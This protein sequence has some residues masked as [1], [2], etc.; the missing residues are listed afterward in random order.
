MA[1][2]SIGDGAKIEGTSTPLEVYNELYYLTLESISLAERRLEID[3]EIFKRTE[4]GTG[5]TV[6]DSGTTVSF[7][8]TGAYYVLRD[9]VRK[10]LD[11]RLEK[12][13][14]PGVP[15]V[16]PE[17]SDL[18]VVGIMA[19]QHYN[20]AYDLAASQLY[21]SSKD[22][23]YGDKD[24]NLMDF[25]PS[26]SDEVF[27]MNMPKEYNKEASKGQ[28]FNQE[29]M[30]VT[31]YSLSDME[32]DANNN[33]IIFTNEDMEIAFPNHRRPLYLEGQI[34]DVFIRQALVDIG[35]SVNSLPLAVLTEVGIPTSKVVRSKISINWFRNSSEE[36]IGYIE[37]DLK[38]SPINPKY[39][40]V[41]HQTSEIPKETKDKH[42]LVAKDESLQ[43]I[44]HTPK[45]LDKV[46]TIETLMP[47]NKCKGVEKLG[48]EAVLH[49]VLHPRISSSNK[50]LHPNAQ[51]REGIH[52]LAINAPFPEEALEGDDWK[53]TVRRELSKPSGEL[54]VKC[55]KKYI[56]VNRTLYK[57]LSEGMLTRSLRQKEAQEQLHKTHETTCE[58][59]EV[60]S[61]YR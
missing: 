41:A 60:V 40:S 53:E 59:N 29:I 30:V 26:L 24:A 17:G 19:Q 42:A 33:A 18:N 16:S 21:R 50:S 12:V 11:G 48:G 57:H 5:G 47:L 36:T 9:E 4:S 15:S 3:P 55:L 38:I 61:L 58:V 27:T 31:L 56:N 10:L 44:M 23:K 7:L 8:A 32:A 37:I 54:S 45:Y 14:E 34:N 2:F 6:I 51:E 52:A 43:K 1:N 22:W 13:E 20:V 39:G 35:S 46:S 28:L 49:S 25:A